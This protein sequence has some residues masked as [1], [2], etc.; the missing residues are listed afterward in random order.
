M[1]TFSITVAFN[2]THSQTSLLSRNL[3]LEFSAFYYIFIVYIFKFPFPSSVNLFLY[4]W[5]YYMMNT[6]DGTDNVRK[7]A[8]T[9]SLV[10]AGPCVSVWPMYSLLHLSV[11]ITVPVPEQCQAVRDS[12]ILLQLLQGYKVCVTWI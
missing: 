8:C 12:E 6:A 7:A 4:S 9:L 11:I 10:I 3:N 5:G 2:S 1:M